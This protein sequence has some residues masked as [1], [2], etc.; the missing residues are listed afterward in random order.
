MTRRV[1]LDAADIVMIDGIKVTSPLRTAFDLLR[2]KP[3]W[4]ALGYVSMLA[5]AVE[6]DPKELL[7][8]AQRQRHVRHVVQ[9]R[10]LALLVDKRA[11]SPPECWV[12]HLM[13]KAE[14]P[15]PDVQIKVADESGWVFAKID[16]GYEALRIGIEYDGEDFHSTPEQQAHDE[17]RQAKLEELGWI[18]IRVDKKRLREDPFGVVVEIN[19]ALR[20]RGAY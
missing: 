19:T 3:A 14:L 1:D 4:R 16:L 8:Y 11:E 9:A 15:T 12:A 7:R 20:A 2:I 10:E 13:F 6:I 5:R 18:I 17:E